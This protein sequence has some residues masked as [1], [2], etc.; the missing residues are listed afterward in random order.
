MAATPTDGKGW[1]EC[2]R[3]PSGRTSRGA[4]AAASGGDVPAARRAESAPGS[5]HASELRAK[6]HGAVDLSLRLGHDGA[7][8]L[9][10]IGHR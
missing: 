4:T 2:S 5:G 10:H 9:A 8:H 6:N 3:L 7:H 1:V